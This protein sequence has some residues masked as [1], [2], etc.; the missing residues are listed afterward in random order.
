MTIVN[1]F[2]PSVTTIVGTQSFVNLLGQGLRVVFSV[3]R[4]MTPTPDSCTL[5]LY[6]MDPLRRMTIQS[7]FVEQGTSNMT[8]MSGYGGVVKPLFNGNVRKMR[9]VVREGADIATQLTGD[10]GGDIFENVE[11]NVSYPAMGADQMIQVAIAAMVAK[12]IPI[13][14]HPSVAAVIGQSNPGALLKI[15]NVVHVGGVTDL[16]DEA[17][18]LLGSRWWV[19]DGQLM[20][21]KQGLPSDGVAGVVL[22]RTHWLTEPVED[23]EDI[24]S[25]ATFLDPIIVPGRRIDVIGRTLPGVPESFRAEECTYTGDTFSNAPFACMMRLRRLLP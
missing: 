21:A 9:G 13:V 23:D 22:P 16:L 14:P 18:R 6:N 8:I 15:H 25:L 17:A 12:G 5:A 7:Q 2:Q 11:M 24:V 4:T 10:D 20:L 3:H 1:L 19:R